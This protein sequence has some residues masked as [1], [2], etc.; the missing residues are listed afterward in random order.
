[1]LNLKPETRTN[2][3]PAEARTDVVYLDHAATTALRSEALE[4]MLPYLTGEFGNPSSM[5]R[6]GQEARKGL[7]DARQTVAQVLDC[8]PSEV[9][10]TS[11]GTEADN[12]AIKASAL[13]LQSTGNHIITT[14]IEHH[15]V[16]HACH[17]MERFGFEV[18]YLP[19]DKDG[20][21]APEDVV[22]AITDRTVLVSVMYANNET[23]TILPVAEIARGVKERA[24]EL[25]RTIVVHT[26]AVQAAGYLD[27]ST[28]ALGVD[29]LSLSA[30]KF[31]GP[32]GVG[33]LYVRRGTPFMPLMAGGGQER[34]HRS[35]TENIPGIAGCARAL[36]LAE[37]EREEESARVGALRDRLASGLQELLPGAL[38]NGHPTQRLPN[39]VNVSLPGVEAEPLLMGLDL[40]GV[41]AS[42]GS[43]CSTGSLEP[44]H[45]LTA[46]GRTA[47]IAR[48]SLR[49]TLGRKSSAEDVETLLKVLPD[50]VGRL[51][52][53]SVRGRV[54]V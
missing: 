28:T 35:G 51:Q 15:A 25:G 8:R 39:N 36:E 49:F 45:V 7:D 32:K 1:M 5:H 52:R 4:A 17:Q 6:V 16:L 26:D 29:L 48:S 47:E 19:V 18:T 37:E 11:G 27:L 3:P 33:V 42:S 13:A 20:L 46:L 12:T 10:F 21:V 31:Y 41:C 43:A 44:S 54:R 9:V 30:H 14:S 40:A 23:G 50:L 53:T 38:L 24:R 34:E 2:G 22:R